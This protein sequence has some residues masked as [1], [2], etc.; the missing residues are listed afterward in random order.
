MAKSP[1]AFRTISEV[2]AWLET[3]AHVLRFWESKF[4]QVR[5]VKRAGGRRYY[6]RDDILL[7]GGIKA[8]LHDQGMTIRG[9]Q[10]MLREQ[11]PR[12]VATL[13]QIPLPEEGEAPMDLAA[14][15]MA[16]EIA[17]VIVGPWPGPGE[18][19]EEAPGAALDGG[20][21]DG[22]GSFVEG[23]LARVLAPEAPARPAPRAAAVPRDATGIAAAL[24][25][26]GPERLRRLAPRLRPLAERLE[27]LRARL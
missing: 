26:A 18:A 1:D 27:G 11:G 6:R 24:R 23:V 4:P 16:E 15:E 10:K 17:E 12:H 13:C 7:L 20:A 2:S 25:A 9:V 22:S 14:E 21:S 3:P 8:L 5:P 19:P